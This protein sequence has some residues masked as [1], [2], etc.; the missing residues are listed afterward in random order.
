MPK[1]QEIEHLR[2]LMNYA[3]EVLGRQHYIVLQLSW[4]LDGMINEVMK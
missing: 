3:A 1:T 2:R 4:R